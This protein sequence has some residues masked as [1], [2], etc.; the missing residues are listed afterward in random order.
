VY[1]SNQRYAEIVEGAGTGAGDAPGAGQVSPHVA[2][3]KLGI[4]LRE[5]EG[6]DGGRVYRDRILR[7]LPAGADMGARVWARFA[8]EL[9]D[10]RS[11]DD[12]LAQAL[13]E[14]PGEL[15]PLLEAAARDS[16]YRFLGK[17][18]APEGAA[19]APGDAGADLQPRDLPRLQVELRSAQAFGPASLRDLGADSVGNLVRVRGIVTAASKIKAK[20]SVVKLKCRNC[21]MTMDLP[22]RPGIAAVSVPRKCTL[23]NGAPGDQPCPLDPFVAVPQGSEFEDQQTLKLQ[24][25][26][27]DVPPGELPRSCIVTVDRAL[28]LSATPGSRVTVTG[29][30]SIYN[31][32]AGKGKGAPAVRNPYVRAVGIEHDAEGAGNRNAPVFTE[33]ELQEFREFAARPDCLAAIHGR[34]APSIFGHEDVKRAVACALFAGC[35]K[36]LPSGARLRGDINVLLLGDPSTAKSQFLKFAERSAPVAVYTSGKGSSAAGLTASV[37]RDPNSGEFYLEGGA[38]VLADGGIVCIDEFDKM[39]AEDRVAIHEAMEQQTISIAKAGITTVLNARAGVLAAANP[40]SG[41]YDDLRTAQENI[42]LQQTILSRFDLIFIV[43]DERSFERDMQI[44]AHVVGVHKRAGGPELRTEQEQREEEGFLR[45]YVEFC[46]AR[47]QP[48]LSDE[49]AEVL[50][51]EYVRI[52]QGNREK[53]AQQGG[54][55]TA[56]PIT[57]RQLEALV[58]ISESLAKMQLCEQVGTEHVRE[59]LRLFQVSTVD[60][61]KSGVAEGI[62]F[63]PE[64]RAECTAIAEQ[65]KARVPVGGRASLRR[66]VEEVARLGFSEGAVR[67]A[68]VFLSQQGEIEEARGGMEVRRVR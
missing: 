58:R 65:V 43:R 5:F 9:E 33:R 47:C 56:I 31:A 11:F 18:G 49:A 15:L 39:R 4:F 19:G 41:R 53:A 17:G 64:Q 25:R 52:R 3:L 29:V 36:H 24:E 55:A 37:L 26:P 57:V 20:A 10:L 59:A 63:T 66:L 22:V 27:E 21:L 48:R 67:R 28:T 13:V 7:C 16:A 32:Q 35:R 2:K 44:A 60:A 38:M 54:G 40:P 68:V 45:R 62:V 42:E 14:R 1:F 61:T 6:P 50:Q 34:V 8:V 51:D 46:R 30:Y 12:D 23:S